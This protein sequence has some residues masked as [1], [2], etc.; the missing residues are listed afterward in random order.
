M[1]RLFDFLQDAGEVIGAAGIA[2]VGVM[3]MVGMMLAIYVGVPLLLLYGGLL[4]LRHF[5]IV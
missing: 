1:R 3:F 5:G 4:I 2:I